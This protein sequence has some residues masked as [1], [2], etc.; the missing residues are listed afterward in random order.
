MDLREALLRVEAGWDDLNTPRYAPQII[1]QVKRDFPDS[2]IDQEEEIARR[3]IKRSAPARAVVFDYLGEL[4]SSPAAERSIQSTIRQGTKTE[5]GSLLGLAANE[6]QRRGI[7]D[8][9]PLDNGSIAVVLEAMHSSGTKVVLRLVVNQADR[10][11]SIAILPPHPDVHSDPIRLPDQHKIEILPPASDRFVRTYDRALDIPQEKIWDQRLIYVTA[12]LHGEGKLAWEDV[13]R[14]NI[15]TW[16]HSVW[17]ADPDGF[18]T[19]DKVEAKYG[20][21]LGIKDV[22]AFNAKTIGDILRNH[23]SELIKPTRDRLIE[24]EFFAAANN[25]TAIEAA[26]IHSWAGESNL[27]I[28]EVPN[29]ASDGQFLLVVD[30]ERKQ[31]GNSLAK[32]MGQFLG[33]PSGSS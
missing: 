17:I 11:N 7:I 26:R 12:L 13:H 20:E 30:L 8:V 19:D 15:V 6:L 24:T 3:L 10:L 5:R 25:C 21:K 9:S 18:L 31:L 33:G 23:L 4:P 32:S 29:I 1:E 16:N 22:K 2:D 28:V 14:L 27:H